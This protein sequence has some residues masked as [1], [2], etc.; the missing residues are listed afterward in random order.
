MKPL[1][2]ELKTFGPDPA[3][4]GVVSIASAAEA[5]RQQEA[6]LQ[7]LWDLARHQRAELLDAGLITGDEYLALLEDHPSVAR[8]ETYDFLRRDRDLAR[9]ALAQLE[10]R[11]AAISTEANRLNSAVKDAWEQIETYVYPV[12]PAYFKLHHTMPGTSAAD[13][14]NVGPP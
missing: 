9:A 4:Q 12:C 6:R 14:G 7:R 10:D 8:F 11:C 5:I 1:C 13:E 3:M 2:C